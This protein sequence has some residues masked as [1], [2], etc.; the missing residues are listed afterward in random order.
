MDAASFVLPLKMKL[1]TKVSMLPVI[2]QLMA[3]AMDRGWESPV[4]INGGFMFVPICSEWPHLRPT[5]GRC[6][7]LRCT[8]RVAKHVHLQPN[9]SRASRMPHALLPPVVT[10]PL[11]FS[12]LPRVEDSSRARQGLSG[13]TPDIPAHRR[14]NHPRH[15]SR[16]S[17]PSLRTLRRLKSLHRNRDG[18]ALPRWPFDYAINSA[19]RNSTGI[20]EALEPRPWPVI[21]CTV[22]ENSPAVIFDKANPR[23]LGVI[24]VDQ[25]VFLS[26]ANNQFLDFAAEPGVG[27]KSCHAA[28]L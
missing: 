23:A 1:K 15:A 7:A 9:W 19:E 14:Q 4:R 25:E 6:A 20:L 3:L 11:L 28:T 24:S 10:A 21:S 5:P 26:H 16:W 27:C 18:D 13:D 2:L 17:A 12:I 8:A 22:H